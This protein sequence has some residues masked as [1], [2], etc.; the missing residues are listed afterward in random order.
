MSGSANG[1]F[2]VLH[3][4]F[5]PGSAWKY[6]DQSW[7]SPVQDRCPPS[8]AISQATKSDSFNNVYTT[9][10]SCVFK[11]PTLKPGANK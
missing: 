1:V 11:S 9:N 10:Y 2:L 4:G 8:C 3:S 5:A 6:W 7:L